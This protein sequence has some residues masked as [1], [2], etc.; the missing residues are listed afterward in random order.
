MPD[1]SRI[2]TWIFDLDDT[3]YPP[4]AR[5]LAQMEARMTSWMM[6]ELGIDRDEADRLRAHYWRRHGTTLAGLMAE[7]GIAPRGWL[8]HVHDI[9][10]GALVPDPV[11]ARRIAALPGRR[12]VFTNGAAAPYAARVLAA[13]DLAHVFDAVYGIEEAGFRCKPDPEAF[14]AI[15]RADGLDPARAAMF[16][17]SAENLR[18]P[19]AMGMATIHVAPKRDSASHVHHHAPDL[20]AFLSQIA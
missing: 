2:R 14:R 13:R 7:H 11:L 16:E 17:D 3:L 19:H 10:L 15:V 1:L 12:I 5:L 6:R 4:E 20:P 8:D 18:A 9:D